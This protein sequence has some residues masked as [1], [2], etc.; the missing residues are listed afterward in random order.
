MPDNINREQY[1]ISYDTSDLERALD[2]VKRLQ[3][4]LN[5]LGASGGSGGSGGGG[6]GS[7][8]VPTPGTSTPGSGGRS[9]S[10]SAGGPSIPPATPPPAPGISIPQPGVVPPGP[11]SVSNT[12][13]SVPPPVPPG[14]IG[15]PP[16]F[17]GFG[18][19]GSG[20]G[21][22]PGGGPAP[23]G[24]M[25]NYSPS[26]SSQG[27]G[28][29]RFMST[30]EEGLGS[31]EMWGR[32]TAWLLQSAVLY[33]ITGLVGTLVGGMESLVKTSLDA[34]STSSRLQMI[35]G[36]PSGGV[37]A[38]LQ[39][40]G[41]GGGL[42][43]GDIYPVASQLAA[44]GMATPGGANALTS[45]AA[46][47]TAYGLFQ[48]PLQAAQLYAQAGGTFNLTSAT[49]QDLALRALRG[50]APD[51]A[52]TLQ[53][54]MALAGSGAMGL[55]TG[56]GLVTAGQRVTGQGAGD[57]ASVL[58]AIANNPTSAVYTNTAIA[59]PGGGTR[60]AGADTILAGLAQSYANASPVNRQII[61]GLA[62]EQN[63]A[64]LTNM[65]TNPQMT[66]TQNQVANDAS[67][68]VQAAIAARSDPWLNIKRIGAN[69][70]GYFTQSATAD[71]V[72]TQGGLPGGGPLALKGVGSLLENLA[73]EGQP[74][75]GLPA[76]YVG[77]AARFDPIQMGSQTGTTAKAVAPFTPGGVVTAGDYNRVMKIYNQL[78]TKLMGTEGY[79]PDMQKLGFTIL[80]TPG[81]PMTV[82]VDSYDVKAL[83]QAQAIAAMG[84]VGIQNIPNFSQLNLEGAIVSGKLG[85]QSMAAR[86]V[87]TGNEPGDD[88]FIISR[89]TNAYN[90]YRR[91]EHDTSY[92]PGGTTGGIQTTPTT[93]QQPDQPPYMPT[94]T[95]DVYLDGKKVGQAMSAVA[96]VDMDRA[97]RSA[98]SAGNGNAPVLGAPIS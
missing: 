41:A 44:L 73:W 56:V 61:S 64:A 55:Q 89:Y 49:S 93:S 74:K 66:A 40:A 21:A 65:L 3:D 37:L 15:Q 32:H 2:D 57:V 31:P 51:P 59:L 94:P 1:I 39:S 81:N 38:G 4:A 7:T 77:E 71:T 47:S 27:S 52:A 12:G 96:E 63:R 16:S 22:P 79:N 17:Y 23:F 85:L 58:A 98:Y 46:T 6:G 36:R 26:P 69:V 78:E 60:P 84:V 50:G 87:M 45:A 62:G 8:A 53:A 95:G 28:I 43:P 83:A 19:G 88:P 72:P 5:Q 97:L 70:A 54:A 92:S 86:N 82:K 9:R 42:G 75:P 13:L 90:D 25:G 76:G 91:G 33:R 20:G 30:F 24:G 18:N 35:T 10:R 29:H 48:S 11:L 80:G 34:A 68:T 14:L 67:A